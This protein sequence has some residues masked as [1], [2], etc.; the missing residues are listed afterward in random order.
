MNRMLQH[1]QRRHA[2]MLTLL[3][4]F[5]TVAT[6]VSGQDRPKSESPGVSNKATQAGRDAHWPS[7]RGRFASGVADHQNL[8]TDWDAPKGKN[9]SWKTPIPGLAHSSPIIWGDKLFVTS[10]VSGEPKAERVNRH[11]RAE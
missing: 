10:A 7:F 2:L 5:L 1:N 9:I 6:T 11:R 4:C 3:L 8:P